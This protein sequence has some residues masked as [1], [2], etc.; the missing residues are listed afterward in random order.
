MNSE[1]SDGRHEEARTPD[2]HR[3]NVACGCGLAGDCRGFEGDATEG[4]S[5]RGWCPQRCPKA[6]N[7]VTLGAVRCLDTTVSDWGCVAST[8]NREVLNP[9]YD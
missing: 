7:Q 4:F 1:E 8:R 6:P 3:V 2:L 9:L 5:D